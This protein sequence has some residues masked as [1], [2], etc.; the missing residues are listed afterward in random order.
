VLDGV[1]RAVQKFVRGG[2][3]YQKAVQE[4]IRDLQRE[5]I[6]ADVN[7]R[8]VFDLTKRIKE[9][10]LKEEPPPGASRRDWFI[11][12]VY[13]ELS[14]LFGGD[15]EP[16]ILPP[17]TPWIILL[18]GVQGS[19]KTTTAGKLAYY[20]GRRR[21]KV[22]LVAADTFRPGAYEQL[23]MLALKSGSL[24]YGERSGRPEDIAGR[25]VRELTSR[26]AEII[27]IDTAGR[28]GY[29]GEEALLEEMKRIADE[30]KPDE[31]I[32]VIDASIGQKAYDL[33]TKFHKST[34]I[35]SII[36][37]KMD[38]TARGGGVLSA[39]AATGAR[40]KFIGTGEKIDEIEPFNPTRFTA[41]ILGLG[42]LESLLERIR[43]L[44]EADRIEKIT[45]D[46]L[47]GRVTMRTLYRQLKA[48]RSM[49]PLGKILQ[50]L[51][52]IGLL[53]QLDEEKLKL[54]EEK[55]DRWLAIIESMTYEE[56][57]NP[58]IID[59]RR[60]RRIAIGSGTR[61]DDVKELIAYYKGIKTMMKRL[62]RDRRILRRLGLR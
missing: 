51:P 41:R 29:G 28:H 24:F 15:A 43:S 61:I 25:G 16:E 18:L 45:E 31:V 4:F 5:L 60:M 27:I 23:K 30:I 32:L 49:G 9:R 52:G 39:V 56:L 40:I 36:V 1:R 26:G 37:T 19:G 44:E 50:M 35:G 6:K 10:A 47:R 7:V 55:I 14:R 38:G 3:T 62:K 2:G 59:R 20:Y 17:K 57:D 11:K 46:M 48:M 53:S 42:D 21:Y 33:A 34:P 8:L 58:D 12:I 54:G 22:G 13:E